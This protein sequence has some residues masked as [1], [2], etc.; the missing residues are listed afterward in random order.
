MLKNAPS[1]TLSASSLQTV[2]LKQKENL[3]SFLVMAGLIDPS[4]SNTPIP[5]TALLDA[6][7]VAADREHY[8]AIAKECIN[9]FV[10]GSQQT[11][12]LKPLVDMIED[13]LTTQSP[14]V[15]SCYQGLSPLA[16]NKV[17][18]LSPT[19]A[20]FVMERYCTELS[21]SEL[22]WLLIVLGTEQMVSEVHLGSEHIQAPETDSTNFSRCLNL[23]TLAQASSVYHH[24]LKQYIQSQ[25][26]L[27]LESGQADCLKIEDITSTIKSEA[28]S[29][30]FYQ[31]TSSMVP[32]IRGHENELAGSFQEWQEDEKAWA[33][34][35][36]STGTQPETSAYK[37]SR[38]HLEKLTRLVTTYGRE[39]VIEYLE[40]SL[41]KLDHSET[42][43]A[44]ETHFNDLLEQLDN[45]SKKWLLLEMSFKNFPEIPDLK[46]EKPTGEQLA[47]C[48][49]LQKTVYGCHHLWNRIFMNLLAG[50][51]PELQE[52]VPYIG[53][54]IYSI[55]AQLPDE[56]RLWLAMAI[57]TQSTQPT[58]D[59]NE[60]H[61]SSELGHT[62]LRQM[63]PPDIV[64]HFQFLARSS[65]IMHSI[66]QSALMHK[67]EPE[68]EFE[69]RMASLPLYQNFFVKQHLKRLDPNTT[70]W[71]LNALLLNEAPLSHKKIDEH[72]TI[73]KPHQRLLAHANQ[74]LEQAYASPELRLLYIKAILNQVPGEVLL[75]FE[76]LCFDQCT[77]LLS[78]LSKAEKSWVYLTLQ[79]G[80]MADH[81]VT[82]S[83]SIAFPEEQQDAVTTIL[84]LTSLFPTLKDK[85]V[86]HLNEL[87]SDLQHHTP[88]LIE[89]L[90]L[91]SVQMLSRG[92]F[93]NQINLHAESAQRLCLSITEAL[94]KPLQVWLAGSLEK[95]I[96]DTT[97][98]IRLLL[99]SGV[100]PQEMLPLLMLVPNVLVMALQWPD[101]KQGIVTQ[102][103]GDAEQI[104]SLKILKLDYIPMGDQLFATLCH[105]VAPQ[106]DGL[107]VVSMANCHLSDDALY[108]FY[109]SLY[110]KA[111][112]QGLNL[113]DNPFSA[114]GFELLLTHPNLYQNPIQLAGLMSCV[115]SEL[116]EP[117]VLSY[118]YAQ[119]QLQTAK[120]PLPS[121]AEYYQ[122]EDSSA[123]FALADLLLA[124]ASQQPQLDAI[125]NSLFAQIPLPLQTLQLCHRA[126]QSG[127][128]DQIALALE[129]A[130][131]RVSHEGIQEWLKTCLEEGAIEFPFIGTPEFNDLFG[132]PVNQSDLMLMVQLTALLLSAQQSTLTRAY[133]L[134]GGTDDLL[135]KPIRQFSSNRYAFPENLQALLIAAIHK[136]NNWI[137][138]LELQHMQ[139]TPS[140]LQQIFHHLMD[141]DRLHTLSVWGNN[142][143]DENVNALCA[144]IATNPSLQ[145]LNVS[146]CELS[147][148]NIEKLISALSEGHLKSLSIQNKPLP[149]TP[150][151]EQML[152]LAEA[153][154]KP[155]PRLSLLHFKALGA[156]LKD[157]ACT[158]ESLDVSYN[159]INIVGYQYLF[160]A[161]QSNPNSRLKH[162]CL[163]QA[164]EFTTSR[165]KNI[166][167]LLKSNTRLVSLEMLGEIKSANDLA[168]L[169]DALQNNF[170]LKNLVYHRELKAETDPER[171][172]LQDE[173][174]SLLDRNR[175][176]AHQTEAGQVSDELDDTVQQAVT[177][178]PSPLLLSRQLSRLNLSNDA[179]SESD[180]AETHLT[181]RANKRSFLSKSY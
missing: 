100:S 47:I 152:G 10:E 21:P 103:G 51:G 33:L 107:Q 4:A 35:V 68:P 180:S 151:I 29:E 145:D 171:L 3:Y 101:I 45:N 49:N 170:T 143:N 99:Q 140:V 66:L 77:T 167:G 163:N 160:K 94:P 83:E 112:I 176:M 75:S 22:Q 74:I 19:T 86:T 130:I 5:K 156:Y 60:S 147:N 69:K 127:N 36:L 73:A 80:E 16:L 104:Q 138:T 50:L 113:A 149:Q 14:N 92:S 28:L 179:S 124:Q 135:V 11:E 96:I 168:L 15:E 169:K 71:V 44:I 62:R 129:E 52:V 59:I 111:P 30:N 7:Q 181:S 54:V 117:D 40:K 161:M 88:R 85:L 153:V 174:D 82:Y 56:A 38:R 159:Q 102:Y 57:S 23:L 53:G 70:L 118:L 8:K 46:V 173:I 41:L 90:G 128:P 78:N 175:Q 84:Y 146:Q 165:L 58:Y 2:D 27:K 157:P 26:S 133:T 55:V 64:G 121:L 91:P 13:A 115:W 134:L 132:D 31:S 106:A 93:V 116:S 108:H 65:S 61:F 89:S 42:Q 87:H 17:A 136:N 164:E 79:K 137:E 72:T 6:Y 43:E 131:H 98:L 139:L 24:A 158:L 155:S 25:L 144:L 63:L 18:A 177:A 48:E 166:A 120:A 32:W 39:H 37:D 97:S 12:D 114:S 110:G 154:E 67:E 125:L 81:Q 95:G 162:L 119:Y 172:A 20:A 1:V 150:G 122:P 126:I 141:K 9:R 34:F 109:H 76:S 123:K 105:V 142:L 148:S 178:K